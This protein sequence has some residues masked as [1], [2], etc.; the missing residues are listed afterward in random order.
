MTEGSAGRAADDP[1]WSEKV[2]RLDEG[3]AQRG[4]PHAF[5]GAIALNYHRDPRS[6]LDID[7][8]IFLDPA[9]QARVL[10]LLD[11]L[12]GL[13]DPARI[14]RQIA[15]DGQARAMWAGTPVD[16]FFAYTEFHGSMAR[17]IVR[18]PFGDSHIPV[19]S[20]E[21]LLV[22]K[23]LFN[24]PKDWLD[25]DAVIKTRREMLDREYVRRW[26]RA[27]LDDDDD[28]LVKLQRSLAQDPGTL[29]R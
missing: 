16:L 10:E 4:V 26:V 19:L 1:T 29:G 20:I 15:D 22:C 27:F 2:L 5:G 21:D 9:D 13:P 24:R 18:E 7:I 28:R 14:T 25:I 12:Y 6:T 23:V 17:R 11:D 8:N 3:L